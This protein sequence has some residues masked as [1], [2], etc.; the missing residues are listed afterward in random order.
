MTTCAIGVF[1]L[2]L[3]MLKG[4]FHKGVALFGILTSVLGIVSAFGIFL[5]PLPVTPQL[6]IGYTL[7]AFLFTR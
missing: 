2:S 4:V 5:S 1:I 6:G 7:Y 3:V